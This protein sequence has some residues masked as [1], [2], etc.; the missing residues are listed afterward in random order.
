VGSPIEPIKI[1]LNVTL[2]GFA[3]YPLSSAE[4]RTKC[5]AAECGPIYPAFPDPDISN[6]AVGQRVDELRK[7]RAFYGFIHQIIREG[8]VSSM[9]ND[10]VP[11]GG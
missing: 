9:I 7:T 4:I 2:L 5:E 10:M 3:L 1:R 8:L 11:F 6:A